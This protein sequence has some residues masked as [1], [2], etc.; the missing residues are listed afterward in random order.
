MV[1]FAIAGVQMYVSAD[2]ENIT[3]MRQRLDLVMHKFPWTQM[4]VFSELAPCGPV[5]SK[6]KDFPHPDIEIFREMAC[7]HHVWLVPG[8]FFERRHGKI[9]NTTVVINPDGELVGR[10]DKM[11][12]FKPYEGGVESGTNFLIFD[13]TDV[14]RFGVSICF[15][16]WFPETTRTLTSE[17][18]EVLIH[19]V[20]T[21]TVDRDVELSIARSTAAM[22]QC[23]VID[24][25]GLG[26]GGNG[27]SAIFNP[28]GSI[29]YQ[30]AGQE[31][32][33]AMEIDLQLVRRQRETGI[34][35]LGQLLKSFRDRSADFP[36]Y[37]R[38]SNA[39]AYLD[40]LGALSMPE[41]GTLAGLNAPGPASLDVYS[42]G[43]T[44]TIDENTAPDTGIPGATDPEAQQT[45]RLV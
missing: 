18:V 17:G 15:D 27:R 9:Y 40:S 20:L 14:G 12:P 24:I 19:P 44:A 2:K 22:F 42:Q 43:L 16:I 6:A 28:A 38:H 11:F 30:S 34:M 32:I 1:P 23:Y 31:D 39:G 10:Y 4:V 29:L 21:G 26:A 3:A 45:I 37:D 33:L 35:G 5:T 7:T 13:V 41:Q 25:N 8:S 36:I